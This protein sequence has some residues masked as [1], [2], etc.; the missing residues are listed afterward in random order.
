MRSEISSSSGARVAGERP[1]RQTDDSGLASPDFANLP[2]TGMIVPEMGTNPSR[3]TSIEDALFTSTQQRVLGILFGH[4][5]RS[6]FASEIFAQA[7]TGRGTV[8]RELERLHESGLVTVRNIGNQKHF[9][10][11]PNSPV[12]HEIRSII[13]KTSGLATPIAEALQP[14]RKRIDLALIYGSVARREATAGSDVDLLVVSDDLL[15]EELF[16]KLAV[17]ERGTGRAIHPALYTREEFSSRRKSNAF[18]RKV[19]AGPVIPIIGSVD[20]AS[21]TR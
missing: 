16:R 4:P 12:F 19:L 5:E 1:Q 7:G 6:F 21:P 11:N 18:V 2:V 13:L 20:A 17:A 10:A 15:L 14:I 9:Q 3:S 8:Q